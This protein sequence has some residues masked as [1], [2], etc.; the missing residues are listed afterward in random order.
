MHISGQTW[1]VLATGSVQ[2]ENLPQKNHDAAKEE[3]CVMAYEPCSSA[4][5]SAVS[6]PADPKIKSIESLSTLVDELQMDP[7]QVDKSREGELRF[8]FYDNVQCVLK[9][10]FVIYS[11][12]PFSVFVSH[13][14]VFYDWLVFK[15]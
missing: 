14:L 2:T 10:Y 13:W 11:V 8:N 3:R 15:K 1:K 4:S 9:F 6:T 7:W 12:L 5:L